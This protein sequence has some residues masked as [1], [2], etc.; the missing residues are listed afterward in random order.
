MAIVYLAISYMIISYGDWVLA[1]GYSYWYWLLTIWTELGLAFQGLG[2]IYVGLNVWFIGFQVRVFQVW[3]Q[4]QG[5]K[6]LNHN[7][8]V[9]VQNIGVKNQNLQFRF[10]DP[11]MDFNDE[12]SSCKLM[13]LY[14][15]N[16]E[17]KNQPQKSGSRVKVGWNLQIQIP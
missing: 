12:K 3:S 7:M 4:F 6:F 10:K 14:M 1:S 2:H 8:I 17:I 5:F 11:I 16:K 9:L 13:F 15:Q